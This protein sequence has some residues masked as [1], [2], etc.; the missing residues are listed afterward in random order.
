MGGSVLGFWGFEGSGIKILA[1]KGGGR[2][3]GVRNEGEG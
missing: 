3:R 2:G 1:D